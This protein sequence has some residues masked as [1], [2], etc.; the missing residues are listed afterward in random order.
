R[1]VPNDESWF[2]FLFE[3]VEFIAKLK[4]F[5]SDTHKLFKYVGRVDDVEKQFRFGRS[6]RTPDT[7]PTNRNSARTCYQH[8]GTRLPAFNGVT[9]RILTVPG[10]TAGGLMSSSTTRSPI[11]V[12]APVTPANYVWF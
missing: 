2:I 9:F 1:D 10:E 12:D 5:S 4:F 11:L 6:S 8:C 7:A 3:D